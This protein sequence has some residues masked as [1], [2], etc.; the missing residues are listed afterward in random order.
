MA[1]HIKFPKDVMIQKQKLINQPVPELSLS[2][3]PVL[4]LISSFLLSSLHLS[5]P[6]SLFLLQRS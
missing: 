2:L 3:F 6:P 4:S 5:L 1:Y